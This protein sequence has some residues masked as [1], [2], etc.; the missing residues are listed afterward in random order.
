M[1]GGNDKLWSSLRAAASRPELRPHNA[2]ACAGPGSARGQARQRSSINYSKMAGHRKQAMSSEKGRSAKVARKNV[3]QTPGLDPSASAAAARAA[4][5]ASEGTPSTCDTMG[6]GGRSR[7]P[8]HHL[9][10]CSMSVPRPQ[11]MYADEA[12]FLAPICAADLE[13]VVHIATL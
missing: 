6:S 7:V 3:P 1:P 11:C 12:A 4:Y 10:T 9:F 8:C 2:G 5:V 13:L